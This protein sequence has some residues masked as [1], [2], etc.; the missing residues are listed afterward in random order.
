MLLLMSLNVGLAQGQ[1]DIQ[2]VDLK[3]I[4]QKKV[5]NL[6]I[7]QQKQNIKSFSELTTSVDKNEELADFR[8]YEKEYLMKED[9]D[10]VWESYEFSSQTDVWDLNKISFALLFNRA[11]ESVFYSNQDCIGLE[12]GQIFY[13]NL[14]ILNGFYS[15]PVAFEIVNVD[16]DQKIIELSYLEGGKTRGKQIISLEETEKG[17]TRII[18]K[19]IVKSRSSMRDKYLYP[20]FHNKLINEFHANMRR[21]IARQAKS[22]SQFFAESK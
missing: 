18:H 19:S 14:K 20:Y 1:V 13:L 2:T 21:L 9:I 11:T 17:Y 4:Q 5:R 3:R 22:S 12:R 7:E 16:P 15:L 8:T 10:F 6:I